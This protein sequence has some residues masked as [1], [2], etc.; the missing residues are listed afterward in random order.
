MSWPQNEKEIQIHTM[1]K[2]AKPPVISSFSP[3]RYLLFIP[4]EAH[5]VLHYLQTGWPI[6]SKFLIN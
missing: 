4:K 5:R 6:S 3:V 2:A 1:V